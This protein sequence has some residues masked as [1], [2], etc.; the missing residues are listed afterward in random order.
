MSQ[1][2]VISTEKAYHGEI[3]IQRR[4]FCT[5]FINQKKATFHRIERDIFAQIEAH[6]ETVTC[7]KGCPV[8]CVLYIEAN[9]QECEAISYYLYENRQVLNSFIK[10]YELWRDKMKQLGGSFALCERILHQPTGKQLSNNDMSEMLFVLKKYQEQNIP[11]S[12]LDN[13]ACSIHE[14]RP[15]V[16]ANHFVS[17]PAEWCRTE[18]WCN[19]AFPDRPKIYMTTIDEIDDLFFYKGNL[20]KPVIGFMPTMAY[21]ILTEGLD[22]IAEATGLESLL[23]VSGSSETIDT[24][25]KT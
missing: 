5:N 16:C 17:T 24:F 8:C 21:R 23:S 15:Y 20:A 12:F 2:T 19:P 6:G 22:Y 11:C 25:L 13:G 14:V 3:G 10:R 4:K 1:Y 18:N 9:I 7:R